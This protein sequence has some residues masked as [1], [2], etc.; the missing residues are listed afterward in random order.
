[1]NDLQAAF[2]AA[3]VAVRDCRLLATRFDALAD[4]MTAKMRVALTGRVSAGKSTLANA[5]LGGYRAPTGVNELTYNVNWICHGETPSL[6]VHYSDGRAPEPRHV[7]ELENLTVSHL[8]GISYL[9]ITDPAPYLRAFDLVDTPGL[10]SV[11]GED[12]ANT[13]RF[14]HGPVDAVVLVFHRTVH[15]TD[16]QLL[17]RLQGAGLGPIN[18]IGALTRVED[19]W[20]WPDEP[21]PHK[22][23]R[24]VVS[25]VG[26]AVSRLV[27][28]IRPVAGLMAA[29][30][31]TLTDDDLAELQEIARTPRDELGHQ[32]GN[33]DRFAQKY[34]TALFSRLSGYGVMTACDIVRDGGVGLAALRHELD[35]RSGMAAFRE[36]LVGHFGN[37][38]ELIKLNQA[39]GRLQ[40]MPA[41]LEPALTA[42][43]RLLLHDAVRDLSKR[44]LS[45][46]TRYRELEVLRAYYDGRLTLSAADGADLLRATGE[47]GD[48]LSDRLGLPP[49]STV[50]ELKAVALRQSRH[51]AE[52]DVL[53]GANGPTRLAIAVL[54]RTYDR[55]LTELI[56]RSRR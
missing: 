54:R 38:A 34:A 31:A 4:G 22:V 13:M 49:G 45:E 50:D 5:L 10:D 9:K 26:P 53:G 32:L 56:E 36:L 25:Q 42:R 1:M 17:H 6:T 21:D 39:F 7:D 30:A 8:T 29:G 52:L 11:F 37:R 28:E 51:W 16:A 40:A 3:R 33:A 15:L 44:A 47:H 43:E 24:R 27:Y 23:A 20:D 55:I 18:A 46:S 19:Y 12:S 48:R 2:I 41:D 35:R 14:L